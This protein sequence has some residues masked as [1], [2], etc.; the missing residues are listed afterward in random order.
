ML[1]LAALEAFITTELPTLEEFARQ[2]GPRY[3]EFRRLKVIF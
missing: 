3:A 2:N 1:A